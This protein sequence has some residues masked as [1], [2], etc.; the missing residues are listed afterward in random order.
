M[1]KGDAQRALSREQSKIRAIA[2]YKMLS[3]GKMLTRADIARRL[4][5]QYGFKASRKTIYDDIRAVDRIM[6][7]E[8][9]DDGKGGYRKM[10]V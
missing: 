5:T 6:P 3:D 2:V 1:A 10:E 8:V 4:E 7:I 9:I